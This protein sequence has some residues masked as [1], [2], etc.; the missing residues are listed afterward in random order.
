MIKVFV[1]LLLVVAFG[2]CKKT[3]QNGVMIR[4]E[5]LTDFTLDSVRL[6]YDTSNYNYGRVFP[7]KTTEYIL[8]KSMLAAPTATADSVNVKILAGRLIPPNSY[9]Y[10]KL[11]PGKCSK[12]KNAVSQNCFPVKRALYTN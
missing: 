2:G 4:I 8:F 3:E 10:P 9:D 12:L 5:N 11:A 7:G 1:I 6:L